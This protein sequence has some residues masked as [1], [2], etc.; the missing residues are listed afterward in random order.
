MVDQAAERVRRPLFILLGAVA[1]VLAIAAANV[2]SLLIGRVHARE[3]ELAVRSALGATRGRLARQ[4]VTETLVLCL[5][6]MVVGLTLALWG[7]KVM[8]SLVPGSLPRADDVGFDWRGVSFAGPLALVSAPRL[9]GAAAGAARLCVSR[10]PGGPAA[11]PR[12]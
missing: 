4:L 10:P 3:R 5:L 12:G 7:T 1:F 9:G 6:G 8:L 2:T 11:T